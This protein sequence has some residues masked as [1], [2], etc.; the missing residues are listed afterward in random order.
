MGRQIISAHYALIYSFRTK[1]ASRKWTFSFVLSF[2][3]SIADLCIHSPI[4]LYGLVLN[5][6]STGTALNLRFLHSV[7]VIISDFT[8][9]QLL[10]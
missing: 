3:S 7:V 5:S 10:L 6:L 1:N 8:T 9:R 2:N 4:Y